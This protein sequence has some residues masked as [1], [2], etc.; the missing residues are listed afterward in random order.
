M[1]ASN[2]HPRIDES[3]HETIQESAR[4]ELPD[5]A[6]DAPPLRADDYD[7]VWSE[8]AQM[9]PSEA[10]AQSDIDRIEQILA[11]EHFRMQRRR[12][13]DFV[14]PPPPPVEEKRSGV[15]WAIGTFIVL[16]AASAGA[17]YYATENGSSESFARFTALL[18]SPQVESEPTVVEKASPAESPATR[19]RLVVK[20]ANAESSD[21]ILLGVALEG[22]ADGL[23]ALVSG[24]AP[25]STLTAGRRWGDTG[26]IV[27]ATELA[28]TFLRPPSGFS[29][30]MEYSVALRRGDNSVIDRQSMRLEWTAPEA[31]PPATQAKAP[32]PAAP[33]PTPPAP[34][35]QARRLSADEI[36]GMVARGEDLLIQGDIASARL[37][38]QRAADAQDA[39]AAFALATSY[40]PIELKRLR[41]YGAVSDVKQARDWY[42]KAKVYGSRE[43][44]KRLELLASQF[45]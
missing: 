31:P 38:L 2:Q 39:R 22:P 21:Q 10:V 41:V 34:P 25:G 27:P 6:A 9:P 4:D 20:G 42:E 14:P 13:H 24:L 43:A 28:T 3:L 15:P 17:A 8:Q 29:G 1:S 18:S 30:T 12:P 7:P 45:R 44:P 40:D 33:A 36:A 16:V 19:T 26:W 23:N 35:A 5:Y 11:S 32:E 37:L